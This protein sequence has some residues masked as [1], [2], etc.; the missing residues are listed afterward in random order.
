MKHFYDSCHE[1]QNIRTRY[2]LSRKTKREYDHIESYNYTGNLIYVI[3]NLDIIESR[4][5]E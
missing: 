5:W 1:L 2:Y 4:F 3:S